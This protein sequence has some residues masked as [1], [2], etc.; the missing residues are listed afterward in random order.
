MDIAPV[1]AYGERAIGV[2]EIGPVPRTALNED[3]LFVSQLRFRAFSHGVQMIPYRRGVEVLADRQYFLQQF[4][5][6]AIR[7]QGG[8]LRLQIEQIGRAALGEQLSQRTERLGRMRLALTV[9]EARASEVELPEQAPQRDDVIALVQA[10]LPTVET[11]TLRAQVL[12][13]LLLHERLLKLLEYGLGL[14]QGQPHGVGAQLLPGKA[15]DLVC[16]GGLASPCFYDYLYT[17]LH[18]CPPPITHCRSWA[19]TARRSKCSGL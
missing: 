11:V 15:G 1:Q 12:R 19:F 17:H 7:H 10:H 4:S 3:R 16:L 14:L 9:I 6:H 8:P 13:R 5:R 2:R 18:R